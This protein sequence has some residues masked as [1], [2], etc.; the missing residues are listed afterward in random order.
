MLTVNSDRIEQSKVET[1]KE[2]KPLKNGDFQYRCTRGEV[3]AT[4]IHMTRAVKSNI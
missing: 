4:R 1:V 3:G 2:Y